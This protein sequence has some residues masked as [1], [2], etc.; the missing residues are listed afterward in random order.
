MSHVL[1]NRSHK[2]AYRPI[3]AS[4]FGGGHR[5]RSVSRRSLPSRLTKRSGN[6]KH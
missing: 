6:E 4:G 3:D 1:R 5:P 2:A